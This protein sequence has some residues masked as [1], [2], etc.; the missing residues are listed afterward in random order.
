MTKSK[1][2]TA[3]PHRVDVRF[4][5]AEIQHLDLVRDGDT[6]SEFIRKLIFNKRAMPKDPELKEI[7]RELSRIGSNLNQIAKF[8]N[9]KKVAPTTAVLLAVIEELE[10][11][12]TLLGGKI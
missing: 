6:R 9:T 2:K 1:K 10:T 3:R 4:S 11:Q 12:I 7:R 8:S 5:D